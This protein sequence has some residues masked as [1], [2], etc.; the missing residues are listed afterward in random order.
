MKRKLLSCAVALFASASLFAQQ[1]VTPSRY[2]FANQ[3]VGAYSIDLA[4]T[5]ANPASGFA[6]AVEN[7]N[8]GY[9]MINNG[10]FTSQEAPNVLAIKQGLS[11]VD[12]GDRKS[13]V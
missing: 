8:N 9:I 4:S 12:L 5:G 3:P 2:V 7:F 6:G 13:V 10:Q 1:D 11:I